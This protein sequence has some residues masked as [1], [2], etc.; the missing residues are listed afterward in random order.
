MALF[1]PSWRIS[2][3]DVD[4]SV[5]KRDF[6]LTA[7][8]REAHL[9]RLEND[10]GAYIEVT[11]LGASLVTVMMPDREGKLT[12]VVLGYD[13]AQAYEKGDAYLGAVIGRSANRI[14]KACMRL[15][16]RTYHLAAN[17][18]ENN[19]HSGPDGYE[20]RLWTEEGVDQR[21]N[22][23]TLGLHS[24]DRDQGYPGSLDISVRYTLSEDNEVSI[25]YRGSSD[26]DTIANLTNHSYFNLDGQDQGSICGHWVSIHARAFT[27]VRDGGAIPT[28]EICSVEG[29]PMD[30]RK[31]QCIGEEIDAEYI[32][33]EVMGGYDHNFVCEDYEE[34]VKRVVACAR[35]P[36]SGITMEVATD[37]PGMQFYTGNFLNGQV[38]KRGHVYH[39][40]DG[41]CMETQYFP[42][43]INEEDF[44]SPVLEAGHAY[45]TTTSYRFGVK[46]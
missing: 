15:N 24:P 43:S 26:A 12:D 29:T 31:G 46:G 22:S 41:F 21:G 6:G 30:L 28:G 2:L 33:L 18:G 7:A 16:G 20:R 4:M 11:D 36:K 27:P 17:D 34:G 38:G 39:R 32:Q 35:G 44:G 9:Y 14:E 42:N 40:R 3:E 45:R 5:S 8:G 19:L 13:T 10:R 1:C 37:L 23:V 25:S